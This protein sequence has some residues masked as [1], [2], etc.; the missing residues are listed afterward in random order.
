MKQMSKWLI[1]ALP[2]A[3]LACSSGKVTSS[4]KDPA[5]TQQLTK[6]KNILVVGMQ[7]NNRQLK[8]EMENY[9]VESLKSQGVKA[10]ASF[11]AFGPKAFA[12][13]DDDAVA[14]LLR[15]KG[16]DGIVTIALL[17]KQN[18]KSYNPGNV[19]YNPVGL[20]Y[21]RFGRYYSTVYDRIYTPG[22]YSTSTDYFWETNIY[23]GKQDKLIYSVQSQSFDPTSITSMSKDYAKLI[24]EDL[25]KNNLINQ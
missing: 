15:K 22:Y 14:K 11:D 20:Y 1:L 7:A 19:S 3:L 2:L 25:E 24:V 17:D 13:M 9:L 10:T 12:K 4:W 6:F 8:E 21:N 16:Y 5:T 18:E 23:D